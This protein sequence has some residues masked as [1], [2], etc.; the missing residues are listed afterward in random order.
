[1]SARQPLTLPL[2]A[3]AVGEVPPRVARPVQPVGGE[4]HPH[5]LGAHPAWFIT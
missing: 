3:L 1:M 5:A 4:V 2:D